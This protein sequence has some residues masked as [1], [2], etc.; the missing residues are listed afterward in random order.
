TVCRIGEI[1]AVFKTNEVLAGSNGQLA[2]ELPAAHV[3]QHRAGGWSRVG[4]VVRGELPE[5]GQ[6]VQDVQDR[7]DVIRGYGISE[8]LEENVREEEY[9]V[10]KA[11]ADAVE[12]IMVKSSK[13]IQLV[14]ELFLDCKPNKN[15][16]DRKTPNM[17]HRRWAYW[18]CLAL[19]GRLR[20]EGV[21][22]HQW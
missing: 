10:M 12:E 13:A 6:G 4:S 3:H 15:Q 17:G 14:D 2:G 7:Y 20:D 21:E 5:E 1:E 19:Y 9:V 11:E 18:E 22:V 16:L 8:W